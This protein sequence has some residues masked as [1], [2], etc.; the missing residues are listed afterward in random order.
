MK[1]E[2]LSPSWRTGGVPL[3]A[4]RLAFPAPYIRGGYEIDLRRFIGRTEGMAVTPQD[5]LV[6]EFDVDR[7]RL[8]V[9]QSAG[10]GPLAEVPT[11]TDL[12][13]VSPPF[14]AWGRF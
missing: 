14:L 1:A 8:K 11:G 12:S 10:E 3:V 4:G 2:V 7:Q 13:G 9:L 5:G 6:F